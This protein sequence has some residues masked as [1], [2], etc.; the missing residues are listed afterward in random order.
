MLNGDNIS[1][2]WNKILY[3]PQCLYA[4]KIGNSHKLDIANIKLKTIKFSAGT[5]SRILCDMFWETIDYDNLAS[6]LGGSVNIFDIACGR[7]HYGLKYR[8]L[9]KKKF[10]SYTGIDI[11][12]H[13]Q[14]PSEFNHILDKAE[15]SVNY[16]DNHNM[17]TSQSG[18]EHIEEDIKVLKEVTS[19]LCKNGKP[20]IQIHLVPATASLFLY[21]WHGWRQYSAKNLG[22]I[23][24]IL[25]SSNSLTVKVVPLG[26]WRSF[27]SHFTKITMPL[28]LSRILKREYKDWNVIG[29]KAS[30]DIESSVLNDRFSDKSFPS[31]WALIICNNDININTLFKDNL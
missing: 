15:C 9:L 3:F 22:K 23:S 21:L 7:G 26:G 19:T 14:F 11:Y 28:L 17:I 1:G 10:G 27:V 8:G 2:V 25:S 12:K 6:Q 13:K 30:S 24:S 20:F 18:L 4:A 29:T 5:P 16:L 31:F